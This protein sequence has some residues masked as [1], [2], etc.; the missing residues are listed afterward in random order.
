M[1]HFFF[2]FFLPF[3]FSSG[4]SPVAKANSRLA[5]NRAWTSSLIFAL[6]APDDFNSRTKLPYNRKKRFTY[7]PVNNLNVTNDISKLLSTIHHSLIYEHHWGSRKWKWSFFEIPYRL[8]NQS[9]KSF[10]TERFFITFC[11]LIFYL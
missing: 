10:V 9:V 4:F 5:A 3:G 8:K 11:R 2:P 6:S 1:L 7:K